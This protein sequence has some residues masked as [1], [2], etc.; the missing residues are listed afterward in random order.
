MINIKVPATTANLCLGYDT[1]G[2]ALDLF[3]KFKIYKSTNLNFIGF[4]SDIKNNLVYDSMLETSK[5]IG[6][7]IGN[8]TIE[9]DS[10][11]PVSR[12]LGS[13]ATC[14]VAGVLATFLLTNTSFTKKDILNISNKIEGHPDNVAP[15]IFGGLTVSTI[16]N[17]E[18]YVLFKE[19]SDKINIML[20]IPD[21]K[22]ST[23]DARKVMPKEININDAV[24]N[25]S[26]ISFLLEAL[27]END[28]ALLENILDD[29]IH[30]PYRK[31]LIK[32]YELLKNICKDIDSKG[33]IISGS[34]STMLN[35]VENIKNIDIIR[36]KVYN[37]CDVKYV[38]INKIGVEYSIVED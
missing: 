2:L 14:V 9:I 3:A 7:D 31:N 28:L 24:N 15:A 12:G 18:P 17:N 11:I 5:I 10:E 33:F 1:L 30:E 16:I 4:D 36:E 25:L 6:K 38:K 34:G 22:V 37:I 23:N 20:M 27:K 26:K 29:K 19:I 35:F 13:S 8:V 21:Y 32:D